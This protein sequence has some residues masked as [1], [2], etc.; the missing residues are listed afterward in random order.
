MHNNEQQ[1]CE[2]LTGHHGVQPQPL[3]VQSRKF[4]AHFSIAESMTIEP[5]SLR[6]DDEYTTPHPIVIP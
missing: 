4:A 6:D 1:L 3:T 5:S 2:T